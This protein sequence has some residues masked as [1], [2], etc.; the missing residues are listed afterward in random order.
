[1]Y[2]NSHLNH[3]PEELSNVP[4]KSIKVGNEEIFCEL[5]EYTTT[6][7]MQEDMQRDMVRLYA[8]LNQC[9][10]EDLLQQIRKNIR[11]ALNICEVNII[12]HLLD[13]AGYQ[14]NQ[15]TK[16]YLHKNLSSQLENIVKFHQQ[17]TQTNQQT[18][19]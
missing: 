16:H 17:K 6:A 15:Q 1:M 18:K 7:A 19:T 11:A 3:I 5:G 13:L 14:M 2:A 9:T 12:E 4:M 8:L 10:D